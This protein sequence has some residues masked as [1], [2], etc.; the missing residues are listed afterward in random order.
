MEV[1]KDELIASL[2]AERDR[3]ARENRALGDE[4]KNWTMISLL[5]RPEDKATETERLLRRKHDKM[6][7]DY[8]RHLTAQRDALAARVEELE[9]D[10]QCELFVDEETWHYP[11]KCESCGKS[12]WSL[13]CKHER[14]QSPKPCG[15]PH[16]I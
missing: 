14:H 3:L 15:C 16:T 12:Y 4:N 5:N 7:D 8:V 9:D 6:Q 1:S 2:T 11:R 13:H 10:C